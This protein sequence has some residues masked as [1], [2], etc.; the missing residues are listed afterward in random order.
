LRI[1]KEDDVNAIKNTIVTVTLL[2]VGY[3]AYVVLKSPPPHSLEDNELNWETE[4]DA[5]TADLPEVRTGIESTATET[6]STAS[7]T[8][9]SELISR[10]SAPKTDQPQT[11]A[12]DTGW[13]DQV[14]DAAA[15]GNDGQVS[16]PAEE[17]PSILPPVNVATDANRSS[18]PPPDFTATSSPNADSGSGYYDRASA[19]VPPADTSADVATDV[20]AEPDSFSDKFQAEWTEVQAALANGQLDDALRRL[21]L[22]YRDKTLAPADFEQ[23]VNLL[24]QLA[25]S[26][27]YS[28]Q[29]YLE[30]AYQV[31]AD[32]T[33]DSIGQR[34]AV[35]ATF[36][37]QVNGLEPN[38]RPVAGE[39]LKVV[40]GPFNAEI[41]L[42][43]G[44]LTLFLGQYYAGRFR[45]SI[46]DNFPA[47]A[48]HFEVIEKSAGR[49]FFDRKTGYRISKDDPN[50]PYGSVWIG[51]RG[52]QVT[53]GHN[54]GIHV[55]HQADPRTDCIGVSEIDARDL[56]A[57][58]T[59]GSKVKVIQ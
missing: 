47:T 52:D 25:G 40:R 3:G 14:D 21:S 49:E 15:A 12:D 7:A 29:A 9:D 43:R 10:I 42:Q 38:Y 35:P 59:V 46:G 51:L 23:V 53:A 31:Q 27:I 50:N 8:N 5:G 24:D 48:S 30:P 34:Y 32:E 16:T 41:D 17:T 20:T 57:I 28:D 33:L 13:P 6:R 37:A 26:V 56:S 55:S 4:S 19:D 39:T 2:A 44:E 11:P 22:L 45:V 58:L 36:L 18:S 54:V 1:V